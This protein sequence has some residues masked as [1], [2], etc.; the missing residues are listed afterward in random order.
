[1]E[2][3]LAIYNISLEAKFKKKVLQ[4]ITIEGRTYA[5]IL[6]ANNNTSKTLKLVT[7]VS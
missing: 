2:E 5:L 4:V 7:N 1:M 6:T 3:P